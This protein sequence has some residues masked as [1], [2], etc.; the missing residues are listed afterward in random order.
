MKKILILILLFCSV[1]LYAEKV[2]LFGVSVPIKYYDVFVQYCIEYDIPIVFAA[3]LVEWES[4]WSEFATHANLNGTI[5]KGLMMHNSSYLDDFAL[6]Y[7]KNLKYDP[8]NWKD[9]L[10]IGLKHLSVLRKN[11]GSWFG[12]ICAYNMGFTAFNDWLVNKKV[13]PGPTLRMVQ[14]VFG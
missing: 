11:T 13:L 8:F 4:N 3:R 6:R 14:F 12:A 2:E 7:N 1:F 9:N 5:D 10:R